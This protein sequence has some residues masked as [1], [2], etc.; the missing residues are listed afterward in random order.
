M[1]LRDWSWESEI[2]ETEDERVRDW[3]WESELQRWGDEIR[4]NERE[5][6]TVCIILIPKGLNNIYIF[7]V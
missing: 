5:R 4:V 1:S 3:S 6:V 2:P 7:F